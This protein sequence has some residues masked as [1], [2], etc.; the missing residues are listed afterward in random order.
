MGA[1]LV[2]LPTALMLLVEQG[3][4]LLTWGFLAIST[5][6]N[7]IRPLVICGASETPF[8]LVLFGVFGG[9]TAFGA[10]GLFLGSVIL[11]VLL[12]VW[13]ENMTVSV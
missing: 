1:T 2:W 12:A 13:R 9:L 8:L 7:I 5:I 4:G 11:A 3:L 10:I 6:D